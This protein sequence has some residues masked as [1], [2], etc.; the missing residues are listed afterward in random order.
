MP[1]RPSRA[2][3]VTAVAI[4]V[5]GEE[6]VA[7]SMS[8]TALALCGGKPLV[9][10]SVDAL[11]ALGEVER[12]VVAL[13]TPPRRTH[14][15]V[16]VPASEDLL[17]TLEA[18]LAAVG[19]AEAVIVHDP[20]RPLVDAALFAR[21][22]AE[23]HEHRCDAVIA[24]APVTDTLKRVDAEGVIVDTVPRGEV[25]QMQT[26][27]AYRADALRRAIAR[28]RRSRGKADV[29]LADHGLLPACVDGRV[30][31]VGMPHQ[32]LHVR[33]P[34]DVRVAELLLARDR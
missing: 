31:I 13:P 18:A 25:W 20:Y 19:P 30:R 5:G 29:P 23:L 9:A 6:E 32:T 33:R 26:P 28:A 14:G 8:P 24:A 15:V 4:L 34:V 22:L 12:I 27:Q 2:E 7:E 1:S 11:R 16:S 21:T 3:L 17:A 10:W